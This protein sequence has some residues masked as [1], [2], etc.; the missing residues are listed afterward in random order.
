M[1]PLFAV[2]WLAAQAEE[3]GVEIYSGFAADEILF[4]EAGSVRGVS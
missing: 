2:R 1:T 4:S 3:L